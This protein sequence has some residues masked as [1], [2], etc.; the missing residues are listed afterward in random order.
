MPF[1]PTLIYATTLLIH[2]LLKYKNAKQGLNP[3]NEI[4]QKF[5]HTICSAGKQKCGNDSFKPSDTF[6]LHCQIIVDIDSNAL[7]PVL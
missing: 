6:Y 3:K 1:D 5:W 4:F 2:N 7:V